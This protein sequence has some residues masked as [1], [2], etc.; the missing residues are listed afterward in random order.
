MLHRHDNWNAT[1]I[2]A[3]VDY[4]HY[5]TGR[6]QYWRSFSCSDPS[7]RCVLQS[8][9]FGGST[10]SILINAPGVSSTVVSSFDGYPLAKSGQAGKALT[11]A[12]IASFAGGSIGAVLLMIFAPT[13]ANVALLFHSAEYFALMIVGL[14][15]VAA[16]A[17]SGQVSKALIMTVLGLSMATVG[18]GAL[19]YLP[20]FTMDI[21]DIQSGLNFIALAMAMFALPEAIFLI[22]DPARSKRDSSHKGKI[23]NLCISRKE[24]RSIAPVIGAN[25]YKGF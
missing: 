24:A 11:V 10:S 9:F 6:N 15:A 13:L 23:K 22:L 17:G 20:R 4:R 14:S 5:D 7:R 1:R 21:P 2:R 19:F 18:E 8:N 12:A 3:D 25:Q 16:F